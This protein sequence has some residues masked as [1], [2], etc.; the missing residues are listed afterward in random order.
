MATSLCFFFIRRLRCPASGMDN[1][2]HPTSSGNFITVEKIQR[3]HLELLEVDI[4]DEPLSNSGGASPGKEESAALGVKEENIEKSILIIR[5][6]INQMKQVV[7][8]LQIFR[9]L[10]ET[11]G[12]MEWKPRSFSMNTLLCCYIFK[13]RKCIEIGFV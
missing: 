13:W 9:K 11:E 7:E 6:W 8:I 2:C 5:E 4:F 3:K 10:I 1:I 12:L